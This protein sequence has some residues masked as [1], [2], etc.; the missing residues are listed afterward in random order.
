MKIIDVTQD[1][2]FQNP[3]DEALPLVKC[4]CGHKWEPWEF[5]IS[6]YQDMP[7]ECPYCGTKYFFKNLIH[8][9]RV[10]NKE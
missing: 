5:I 6:I 10:D 4:V 1:V 8:V 7:E 2:S 9:Y 3:D